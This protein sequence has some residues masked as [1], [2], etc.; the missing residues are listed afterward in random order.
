MEDLRVNRSVVIPGNELRMSFSTSG[1]PGGQHANKASTRVD[2]VWNVADS[3]AL[4]PRQRSRVLAA[5]RSR[6][7][8]TGTLRLTSDSHR[9]QLRNRE[10]VLSRLAHLVAVALKP[11][12]PRRA[13]IP[14]QASRERRL[15]SKKRRSEVKRR[16]RRPADD[17]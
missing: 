16:R 7:D 3:R 8:A 5:L 10:E 9:S 4:G 1:G 17:S 12:K 15:A 6:L 11:P 14:T 2:L 13:T